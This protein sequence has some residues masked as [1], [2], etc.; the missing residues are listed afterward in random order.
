MDIL[1]QLSSKSGSLENPAAV[2][3]KADI[4]RALVSTI[5]SHSWI[6]TKAVWLG[7]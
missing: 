3:L 6:Y 4:D 5:V 2:A 1:A 7:P